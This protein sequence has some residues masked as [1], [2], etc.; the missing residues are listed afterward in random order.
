[1]F[2]YIIKSLPLLALVLLTACAGPQTPSLD[3]T[4]FKASKPHSILILPPV[5]EATDVNAGY[6]MMAQMTRPLAEGGYYVLPVSLVSETFRQNGLT[7]ANDIQAVDPAKLRKIFGADAALYVDVTKYGVSYQVLNSVANVAVQA[8]LVDLRSGK[9]LWEGKASAS[10]AETDNDNSS[11]GLVGM[12]VQAA[13]K[14]IV[15]HVNDASYPV[16]G[17][18]SQRLLTAGQPNGLLYGPRSAKFGTD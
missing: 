10:S 13:I 4:A 18:A 11:F 9:M 3:Y 17:I 8:R 16:A 12:L 15:N 2:K 1:M 7:T 6:G 14:Q 5:S